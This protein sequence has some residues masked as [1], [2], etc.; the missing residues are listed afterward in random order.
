VIE[1]VLQ[2]EISGWSDY[3]GKISWDEANEKSKSMGMRLPSD[4]SDVRFCY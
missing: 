2:E 1:N 3:Q 4:I